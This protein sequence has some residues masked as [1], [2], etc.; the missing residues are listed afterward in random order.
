MLILIVVFTT[1]I[2]V[3]VDVNVHYLLSLTGRSSTNCWRHNNRQP[4]TAVSQTQMMTNCR[5]GTHFD[6]IVPW[7]LEGIY[8][9][10]R[11]G[12]AYQADGLFGSGDKL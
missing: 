8:Q 9:V 6:G 5:I 3:M 7:T 11:A 12:S 1:S 10:L 2:I 4:P